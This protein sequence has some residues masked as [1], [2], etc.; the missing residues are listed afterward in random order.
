MVNSGQVIG[1]LLLASLEPQA[2]SD[3]DTALASRV[4]NQIAGAIDNA[5]L[6]AELKKADAELTSI[7][8][9]R[10]KSASQNEAIA[11]IGRVISSTLDIDQVYQAFA[12]QV[13]NLID[14]DVL[15]ICVVEREGGPGR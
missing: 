10:G 15:S 7:V 12:N 3:L 6:F 4:S 8:I 9:E 11:E 2:Y 5:G 14:F 13:R 1:A